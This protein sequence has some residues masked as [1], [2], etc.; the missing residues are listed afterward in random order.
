MLPNIRLR[1]LGNRSGRDFFP[2]DWL[3]LVTAKSYFLALLDEAQKNTDM[4]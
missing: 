3:C 2:I 1:I 4:E